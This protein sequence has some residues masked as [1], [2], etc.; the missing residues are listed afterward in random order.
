MPEAKGR[1]REFR[2]RPTGLGASEDADKHPVIGE[3]VHQPELRHRNQLR[4]GAPSRNTLRL[5]P[6]TGGASKRHGSYRRLT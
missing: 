5:T 6:R 3:V 1:R 4:L 2:R